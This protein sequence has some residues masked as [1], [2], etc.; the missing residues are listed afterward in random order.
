MRRDRLQI[1][2]E[3]GEEAERA[4][5]ANQQPRHVVSG[6]VNRVEV[7][8]ADASQYL[9]EAAR[10]FAAFAH[11][12]RAHPVHEF[13]ITRRVDIRVVGADRA[14]LRSCSPP[15]STASMACTLCTMLP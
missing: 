15:A 9:G 11:R 3:A 2:F 1:E 4:L 8:A 12:N 10:D 6:G 13:A 7:V 14:E 5:G